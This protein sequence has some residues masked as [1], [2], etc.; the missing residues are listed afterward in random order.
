MHRFDRLGFCL[1]AVGLFL[2]SGSVEGADRITLAPLLDDVRVI[3]D[4]H[5]IPHIYARNDHDLYLMMGYIHARDR[6]FQMDASRRQASGTL[7]ELLG[8]GPVNQHLASDVQLRTLGLRR[9]A[10]RSRA[11]CSLEALAVLQAYADGVNA[12]LAAGPLP[13]EYA[14]LEITS[15]GVPRWSVVDSLSIT[16]LIAF[17]LSFDSGDLRNTELLLTYQGFGRARGFDGGKLFFDDLM[18]SAPF[19]PTV[20]IPQAQTSSARV[21]IAAAATAGMVHD[22]S[23]VLPQ[24]V[25]AIRDFLRTTDEIPLLA[26][27]PTKTGGSNWWVISGAKSASGYP[28]LANDPHLSLPT[29]AVFYEIHL[30]IGKGKKGVPLSAY[31]VSFPGAPGVIQGFNDRIAWG[32]TVNAL[33]VTDFYQEQVITNP[34][35]V[36]FATFFRGVVEPL[37]I[38]PQTFRVNL[39]GDGVFNNT[40]VVSGGSIPPA[41]F[42]VPRRNNGPLLTAPSGSP[43]TAISVQ[44]SG[45]SATREVETFLTFARAKNMDDFK[46]G[47]QFFDFGSQNWSYMDTAGNIAYFTSAELPLRE[48]LQDGIVDGSIP[49]YFIRDGTGTLRHEWIPNDNPPPDQA[50]HYEILPFAEMPH[51]INP[52]Q[53]FIANANNDPIG[54]TLDNNPLNQLRPGGG[55]FY[56][57]PGYAIGNRM[58]RIDRLIRKELDHGTISS[59]DMKRIQS[60]VQML[61][62]EVL[63][64]YI[65]AALENARASSDP[66]LAAFAADSAVA[67]AVHRLSAWDFS[68]PTGIADGYD[69]A[70]GENEDGERAAPSAREIENSVAATIYNLWR[71]QILKNT[72]DVTLTGVGLGD[73]LPSGDRSMIALRNLLDHYATNNGRGA[74]GL[75]FFSVSGVTSP[76]AARDLILLQSLKDGL[77]LLAADAFAAAFNHSANQNDYR[78]GKLHRIKFQHLLA[79][80]FSIPPGG[81][82]ADLS[83][84]LP[85]LSTDGGFDVVDA[86]SHN[87]RAA[88]LNGFM[89]SSGPAR[90]FIGEARRNGIEAM[91]V[92]PGGESGIPS[93]PFFSN[94]LRHWLI[95]DLHEALFTTGK[96]MSNRFSHEDFVP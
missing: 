31:G 50:L 9:A 15:E 79:G 4:T 2:L 27:T 86:S 43:L 37:V 85:G 21:S 1:L 51:L 93:S 96:V 29:P 68:A 61:D 11:A 58:G 89:F 19:D 81:G 90:R 47:L 35:G 22:P 52:S 65:V 34:A 92:I 48:D 83:P 33:D 40:A 88:S 18:R 84:A 77:N 44:Y 10:E 38:I 8:P 5:G 32:S 13:P 14:A 45:F 41:T 62:A 54:T 71:G 3:T 57:A 70:D 72:I 75:S 6:F 17:G 46:R 24:T 30:D 28:M 25:A 76:E 20:S 80:S 23:W 42:V 95:N 36:P 82:F 87:P 55:I 53:G 74:S 69:D 49:P 59:S 64:P 66:L 91:Q 16:K 12:W 26:N 63:T 56:L 94:L 73:F 60:N 7:A 67:E 39:V 78:W